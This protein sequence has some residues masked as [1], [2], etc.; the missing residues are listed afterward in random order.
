MATAK[1]AAKTPA[2]KTPAEPKK[3]TRQLSPGAQVDAMWALREKKRALETQVNEISEQLTAAENELM[4]SMAA[5]GLDKMTGKFASVSV[6]TSV[7][8]TVTDWDELWKFII[9]TKNTQLLQRRVS[10]PA[11]RELIELGKK[12]PGANPF[13]KKRLNLRAI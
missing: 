3:P 11:Y 7:V 9:K 2:K 12:V 6:S 4:E 1:P 8:A 10:D 5:N 13:E